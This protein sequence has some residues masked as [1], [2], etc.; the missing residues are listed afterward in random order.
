MERRVTCE[1]LAQLLRSGLRRSR[2]GI[3][4]SGQVAHGMIFGDAENDDLIQLATSADG[5]Y[6]KLHRIIRAAIFILVGVI[7][8]KH[9]HGVALLLGILFIERELDWADALGTF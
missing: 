8:G 6:V 3:F 2:A 7:I 1:T 9:V 5:I 4:G